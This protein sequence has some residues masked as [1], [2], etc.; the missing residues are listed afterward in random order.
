MK[1]KL[2]LIL[3]VLFAI[4]LLDSCGCG[5][6]I[7]TLHRL[8]G[9]ETVV[10]RNETNSL[11]FD[12]TVFIL[13][14]GNETVFQQNGVPNRRIGFGN[15]ALACG[16]TIPRDEMVNP[17][18]SFSIVSN[19]PLNDSIGFDWSRAFLFKDSGNHLHFG[20]AF[21]QA[22]LQRYAF[23]INPEEIKLKHP[24]AKLD[25]FVLSFQFFDV[26]G[27]LF[28]STLDHVILSP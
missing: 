13:D 20:V 22:S 19:K 11:R 21:E 6:T 18:D 23:G 27:N 17:L 8:I 28:E 7:I 1:S 4:P 24:P 10:M 14:F 15:S 9:F 3:V 26:E 25:T 12:S 16:E 5:G 2:I